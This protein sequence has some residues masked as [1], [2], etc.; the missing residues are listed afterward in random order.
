MH[1]G[2]I[3]LALIHNPLIHSAD[4]IFV[5]GLRGHR[6]RTWE[7]KSGK[8]WLEWLGRRLPQVRVWT[9]GY[10]AHTVLGSQDVFH[11]FATQFLM[12]MSSHLSVHFFFFLLQSL[13]LY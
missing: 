11:L 3:G 10:N 9:Y 4:V 5:H 8:F 1:Q 12:E 2:D 7:T 13:Y 6:C